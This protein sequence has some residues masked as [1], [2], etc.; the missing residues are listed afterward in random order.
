MSCGNYACSADVVSE[1]FVKEICS[2]ELNNFQ[3]ALD[4]ADVSFDD[5]C[6]C[7]QNED[8]L[9]MLETEEQQ[10]KLDNVYK[11]LCEKFD[12]ETGLELGLVCHNAEDRG[13]ELDGGSFSV[14]GVYGY[15]PAG[16]KYKDKI[17]R[18]TWTVFG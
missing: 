17:E 18:K 2:E 11:I 3:V 12:K 16:E 6:D 10:D 7:V 5:Y 15:T 1:D 9:Y 14:Y 8:D 13:D 4:E